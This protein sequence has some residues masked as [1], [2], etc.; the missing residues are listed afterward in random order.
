MKNIYL[1]GFMG[2][3]KSSVGEALA[4]RLELDFID[5]DSLIEDKEGKEIVDIFKEKGEEYFRQKE[6][7]TLQEVSKKQNL[8]VACGGGIV[9]K[10][11]NLKIMEASGIPICLKAEPQTIYERTK[12]DTFRPLLNVEN[13]YARIKELLLQRQ[14][15]YD[16]IKIQIDDTNLSIEETALKIEE[17]VK[18]NAGV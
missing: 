12:N 18:K 1:L 13:P 4:R 16:K 10:E 7:E 3:G 5:L 9:L 6:T 8:V 14:P 2:T 11:E 17:I 15:F